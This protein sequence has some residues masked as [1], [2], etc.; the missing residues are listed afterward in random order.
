MAPE[1]FYALQLVDFEY[2]QEKIEALRATYPTLP[3]AT[4]GVRHGVVW[5]Q[6]VEALPHAAIPANAGDPPSI[7]WEALYF[8]ALVAIQDLNQRVAALEAE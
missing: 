6:V 5:E 2:D 7:D 3:D 1:Q 8:A 4:P